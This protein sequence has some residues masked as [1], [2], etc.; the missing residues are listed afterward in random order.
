MYCTHDLCVFQLDPLSGPVEGGTLLTIS[1]SNLGQRAEDVQNSVAVAGIHC[2]VIS[3]RYEVSSRHVIS[4][5]FTHSARFPF[6]DIWQFLCS[7][8]SFRIVCVT[9]TS[10]G[11]K[12][13]QA[14]VK[15]QGGGLGLSDQIFSY[16]VCWCHT[17]DLKKKRNQYSSTLSTRSR[18]S[19]FQPTELLVPYFW[20]CFYAPSSPESYTMRYI[21]TKRP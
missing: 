11:P 6:R 17:V 10:G 12:R 4:S 9:E 2:R 5:H 13:G 20:P 8:A 1:G 15:V 16:Q 7:S 19:Y 18:V 14:S 3:S 21:P